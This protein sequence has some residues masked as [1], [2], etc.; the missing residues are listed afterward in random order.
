ML[1]ALVNAGMWRSLV[2]HTAGGRGVAGSNP[3]IPTKMNRV[4]KLQDFMRQRAIVQLLLHKGDKILLLRRAQGQSAILG[5]YEL[6][7]GRLGK[8]EQPEDSLKRHVLA[9]T[10]LAIGSL[11]LLD[12]VSYADY[13][14][15][16]SGVQNVLI[17]YSAET[18]S[19]NDKIIIESNKYDKYEWQDIFSAKKLALRSSAATVLD[20][21]LSDHAK[22]DESSQNNLKQDVPLVGYGSKPS[23]HL[24]MYSDGGSRGNPGPS[25]AGFVI[26]DQSEQVIDQGGAYL[27]ITT[28]NQAEYHGVRLGLERALELGARRVDVRIDSLL[29]ANQLKGVYAIK[30]RDLWP[31]NE[32]IREIIPKFNKVTFTHVPRALNQLADGMVNK[33]LD[34][35]K[36]NST[37]NSNLL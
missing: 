31:I 36:A 15:T 5:K 29:V 19:N 9:D 24:I 3:V 1:R 14:E 25:S 2:A 4:F 20:V 33:I 26:M 13:D 32:R 18:P 22:I 23:L 8:N 17:V 12:T 37:K 11:K 35:H 10:G 30:S 6:P 34:E 28:N 21:A 7:G 27:G 16:S